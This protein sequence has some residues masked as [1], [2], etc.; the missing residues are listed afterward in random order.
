VG[1]DILDGIRQNASR[2]L[3]DNHV[4]NSPVGTQEEAGI[5][6]VKNQ[7]VDALDS[8][9]PGYRD[10]LASYAKHSEPI[11]TMQSVQKLLDPAA[12]GSLNTAGDPQLAISRLRQVLR[13][14]DKAN[15]PMSD[16]ARQQ[17]D[18]VLQS[19]QRR[20]ISDNKVAASGPGTA[21][22]IQSQGTLGGLLTSRNAGHTLA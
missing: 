2:I 20:G 12:P 5:A 3:A 10:Y 15:Y 9:I 7:I 21:A 6:P 11:N 14:D 13:G 18:G 16:E 19:L 1:S 8:A 4:P 22:D 17:L